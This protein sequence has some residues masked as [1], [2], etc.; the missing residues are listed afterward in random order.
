MEAL[1]VPA[2]VILIVVIVWLAIKY[3][4]DFKELGEE[5]KEWFRKWKDG[6]EIAGTLNK[7]FKLINSE[8][9]EIFLP[10][11]IDFKEEASGSVTSK[12]KKWIVPI[13]YDEDIPK[14]YTK[15]IEKYLKNCFIRYLHEFAEDRNIRSLIRSTDIVIVEKVLSGSKRKAPLDYFRI[16]IVVPEIKEDPKLKE[17]YN[18][19]KRIDEM[20]LLTRIF[21]PLLDKTDRELL[22]NPTKEVDLSRTIMQIFD[23]LVKVATKEKGGKIPTVFKSELISFCIVLISSE[24]AVMPEGMRK[25]VYVARL[26]E[27]IQDVN[28]VYILAAGLALEPTRE[29]VEKY[30]NKLKVRES[31]YILPSGKKAICILLQEEA[32]AIS[33]SR[34]C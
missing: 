22:T 28:T 10:L 29:I 1:G 32:R 33:S 30:L 9:G 25:D 6:H 4:H 2:L 18:L 16:K 20:G 23:I 26:Q 24:I 21:I 31:T 12:D 8:A 11:E 13:K 27:K 17:Y 15:V 14:E 34:K 7:G 19:V 3:R 5:G